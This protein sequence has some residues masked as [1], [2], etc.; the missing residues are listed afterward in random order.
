MAGACGRSEP[1]DRG[2]L[3]QDCD[4]ETAFAHRCLQIFVRETQKDMAG[5]AAAFEH[6]D[7][8]AVARLAHRIKGASASIRATFLSEEA[9]RLQTFGEE[10][11]QLDAVACFSRLQ[12]EFEKFQRFI[13]TLSSLSD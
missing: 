1:L 12:T 9:A 2:R 11:A 13:L 3:L 10:M 7:L 5:I 8:P 4:D 6:Q